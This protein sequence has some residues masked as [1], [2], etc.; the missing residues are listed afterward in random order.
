MLGQNNYFLVGE[1]PKKNGCK[2][3]NKKKINLM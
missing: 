3:D 1:K 2:M